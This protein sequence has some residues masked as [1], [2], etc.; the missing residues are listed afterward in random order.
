MN[1]NSEE[2][3]HDSRPATDPLVQTAPMFSGVQ[4]FG[5]LICVVVPALLTALFPVSYL[6]L[7]RHGAVV[8]ATASTCF[9]YVIPYRRQEVAEVVGVDDQITGG[10]VPR[11]GRSRTESEREGWL[12]L[13]G[14]GDSDLT[15]PCSPSSLENRRQT[16]REFLENSTSEPALRL[17]CIHNWKFTFLFCIPWC[18]LTVL[19]IL[20]FIAIIFL[21]LR[22]R[23]ASSG[24]PHPASGA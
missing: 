10:G 13:N 19:W 12:I 24:T 17:V 11:T 2:V 18:L 5:F 22:G 1:V 16:I 4:L 8:R 6:R 21:K 7:E 14:A 23:V 9:F 15:V 3:P 20:N